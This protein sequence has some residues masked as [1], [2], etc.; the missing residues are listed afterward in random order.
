MILRTI[1][2][3]ED[4]ANKTVLL[5]IDTDVDI[6]N[7]IILDDTRL[8][9]SLETFSDL[10]IKHAH[11]ILIG[12]L[13]RPEKKIE[14][15]KLKMEDTVRLQPVAEWFGKHLNKEGSI[16]TITVGQFP[17]YSITDTVTLLENIRF[18]EGEEAN[19]A[20]FAKHL[21]SLG[22]IFV[23]DA[24]AVSH[25]AH[26]SIAGLPTFL[27]SYAG[28]HLQKEVEELSRVIENPKRPLVVLIGGAKIETKLP[29]VEKMHKV[30]DYVLV[31]GE[32]AEQDK[33]LI[34]VQHEKLEGKK[35]VVLVAE[36]A[37]SKKDITPKSVENFIQIINL[38]STVVW[39]G[40]VGLI[41]EDPL[42]EQGSKQLSEAIVSSGAYT[43]VGGGDS[44][45]FLKRLGLLDKF[46]FVSTGGGAML[47][48]LSGKSLPGIEPLLET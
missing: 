8:Q 48:F 25:R 4:C 10:L 9:A 26:A 11:V 37:E 14:N 46:N 36:M 43:I 41:G 16:R 2:Q 24:F 40:P 32:I 1:E 17:A 31:G 12:H 3:L 35:S 6:K 21:A 13:G 47:E 18:F 39:N 42:Y 7:N 5:R 23:N 20:E 27:P 19:N 30:A 34:Q 38:A 33:I 22:Q 15:G 45:T 29:M 44:L 28:V